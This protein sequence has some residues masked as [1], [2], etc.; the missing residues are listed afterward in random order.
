[1]AE[2]MELMLK[3]QIDYNKELNS[4]QRTWDAN[5]ANEKFKKKVK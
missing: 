2:E 1:M 5:K 4:F 3:R